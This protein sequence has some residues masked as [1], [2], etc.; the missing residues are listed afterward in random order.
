MTRP[1]GSLWIQSSAVVSHG[2]HDIHPPLGGGLTKGQQLGRNLLEHAD[3][4]RDGVRCAVS[5]LP[6]CV[7]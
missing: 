7:G 4:L 5:V 6:G 2:V 3:A 1:V